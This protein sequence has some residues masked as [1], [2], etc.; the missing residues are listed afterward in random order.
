MVASIAGDW[1]VNAHGV[2]VNYYINTYH[3][4][5]ENSSGKAAARRFDHPPFVDAS[6]RREPDFES[7]R[8]SIT[9]LCR[10]EKFA[11]RLKV[12]DVVIYLTVRGRYPG[13]DHQR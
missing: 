11:P 10:G 3:P 12:G 5:C 7:L 9:A 13:T 2:I 6:C 8:P 4:L 1:F